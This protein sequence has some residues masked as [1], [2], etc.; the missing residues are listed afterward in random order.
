MDFNEKNRLM[1]VLLIV[2]GGLSL[3][4]DVAHPT[5]HLL[6]ITILV[7][8]AVVKGWNVTAEEEETRF[9]VKWDRRRSKGLWRYVML[10]GVKTS[11]YLIVLSLYGQYVG[12][13]TN[14]TDI[15]RLIP[16]GFMSI[17]VI[18][19]AILG[20]GL[21]TGWMDWKHSEKKYARIKGTSLPRST[22]TRNEG[23]K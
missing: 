17:T 20:L 7:L 9:M 16:K 19:I 1:L 14:P 6:V 2:A 12:N 15:A 3:L 10:K 13:D 11:L 23:L 22:N 8:T 5:L 18:I 21:F 4:I